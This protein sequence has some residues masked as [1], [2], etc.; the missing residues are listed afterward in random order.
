VKAPHGYVDGSFVGFMDDNTPVRLRQESLERLSSIPDRIWLQLRPTFIDV[1]LTKVQSGPADKYAYCAFDYSSAKSL[2][3]WFCITKAF[4]QRYPS[5]ANQSDIWVPEIPSHL[6][7]YW[8]ALCF[9]FV[10]AEN[11]CVVTKFEKNNPVA[12][13]PE[14]FAD[15][16]LC[17]ANPGSFWSAT[18][19]NHV[20]EEHGAAFE[21]VESVKRLYKTWNLDHC[22]GQFL[23]NTGLK[24]EAYFR[25]FS[26]P[27]F[28]TPWSG[29][30]QIR[31][32]AEIHNLPGLLEQ[33]S[34][35]SRFARKVREEMYRILIG[36]AKYF[37]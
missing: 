1:N 30:I 7:D 4:L 22:R 28:L 25:Y 27:D 5:W 23:Q 33:F 9:A 3:T 32:Y 14:V 17:P 24:S 13:A 16:P 34:D 35:I 37:G 21:L 18:L 6:E 15:N 2:L 11:R 20:A 10:L 8:H 26:Y 19:D 31:K 12:G 36:E 29:L